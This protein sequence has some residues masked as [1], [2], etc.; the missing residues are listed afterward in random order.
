M[1]KFLIHAVVLLPLNQRFSH[2]QPR[3]AQ[4][5]SKAVKTITHARGRAR[6]VYCCSSQ[7]Q[8]A[9]IQQEGP[10]ISKLHPALRQQ[11]DHAANV[12][13]GNIVI[14]PHSN[15]EVCWTCSQCPDGHLH[16][17]S[18]LVFSRTVGCGCPQCSGL[19][20]CKHNSLATKTPLVA[21]EWDYEANDG[22]PDDVVAQSNHMA[23][24][25]CKLCGCNWEAAISARVSKHKAGCPRCGDTAKTKKRTKHPTL[26]ECNHPLMAEWDHKRNAAQGHFPD[27]IRLRSSKRVFWLCAKCPAGQEHSWSAQPFSRTGR[28]KAGCSFCAGQSACRCN[29]LQAL[30]PETA[31]EWD[32]SKNQSQPSDYTASS[33]FLAWWSSPQ[34]GSWRQTVQSRTCGQRQQAARLRRINQRE[35]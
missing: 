35:L 25:H 15:K 6:D 28:L 21:A 11:W 26:A 20:V 13:L 17:W 24:W 27:K 31:V 33:E 30:Y 18:A 23:N 5:E 7:S 3:T 2:R 16:S 9:H 14:K 29:S 19:K 34:R 8:H 12:H 1:T 22:T 32:Y 10:D 4:K